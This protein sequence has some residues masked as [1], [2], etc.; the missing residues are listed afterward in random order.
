[1][2]P[3]GTVPGMHG[4][5]SSPKL[6]LQLLSLS[7]QLTAR[8]DFKMASVPPLLPFLVIHITASDCYKMKTNHASR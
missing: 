3:S 5:F 4:L 2:S 1:M 8:N 6:P 7:A